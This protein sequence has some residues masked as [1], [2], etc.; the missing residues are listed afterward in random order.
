M[1]ACQLQ[2]IMCLLALVSSGPCLLVVSS[3]L[4]IDIQIMFNVCLLA[5]WCRLSTK[6]PR[7]K[8]QFWVTKYHALICYLL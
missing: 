1:C 8:G 2:S 3:I 5:T 6:Y 7:G 4:V